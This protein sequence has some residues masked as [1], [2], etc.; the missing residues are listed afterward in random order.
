MRSYRLA[1]QADADLDELTDFLGE[2]DP[3]WAVRILDGLHERK[4]DGGSFGT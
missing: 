2:R 1:R 4:R 3:V